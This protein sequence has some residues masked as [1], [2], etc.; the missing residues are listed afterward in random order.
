MF[1]EIYSNCH[2]EQ[3]ERSPQ[4]SLII[5]FDNCIFWS[6]LA[7]PM[8]LVSCINYFSLIISKLVNPF[9]QS[10]FGSGQYSVDIKK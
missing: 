2:L 1:I 6:W 8:P 10:N 7:I 5:R 9:F 4:V 3:S